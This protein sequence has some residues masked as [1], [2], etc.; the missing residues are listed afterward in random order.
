MEAR[1]ALAPFLVGD[2]ADQRSQ[3]LRWRAR[4]AM[5]ELDCTSAPARAR[6]ALGQLQ[7]E[8]KAQWPQGGQLRQEVNRVRQACAPAQIAAAP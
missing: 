2:A 7:Q 8:L 4:A 5:A 1:R 3:I 6:E